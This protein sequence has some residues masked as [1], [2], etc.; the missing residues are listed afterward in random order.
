MCQT[1]WPGIPRSNFERPRLLVGLLVIDPHNCID[2]TKDGPL[3]ETVDECLM[4]SANT[5]AASERVQIANGLLIRK[6]KAVTDVFDDVVK[7]LEGS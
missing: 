4:F 5:M 7:V 3:S 6:A 2:I 1:E